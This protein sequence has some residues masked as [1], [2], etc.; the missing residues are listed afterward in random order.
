MIVDVSVVADDTSAVATLW[1]ADRIAGWLRG[2]FRSDG[3]GG[4]SYCRAV[5]EY[6]RELC[7]FGERAGRGVC[8]G[9]IDVVVG[10]RRRCCSHRRHLEQLC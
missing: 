6:R 9:G 2:L 10:C 8:V 7:G 4:A 1:S 3:I 5:A